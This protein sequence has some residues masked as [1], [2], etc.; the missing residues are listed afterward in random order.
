MDDDSLHRVEVHRRDGRRA[1][2]LLGLQARQSIRQAVD[3]VGERTAAVRMLPTYLIVGAQ[4]GGTSALYEYLVR[5]PLIGRSTNE[6]VHYFSVNFYRGVD[7]YKGHFPT[8]FHRRYTEL[9][10]GRKLITG[11]SSPYYMFHPHAP[12]RIADLLP[13]VRLIVALRNPVDRAYS[14]YIHSVRMGFEDLGTFE[15]ALEAEPSRLE[16]ETQRML[17]DP[18]YFGFSHWH[19]SYIARG[20]YLEQL[21]RLHELFQPD[22]ILVVSAEDMRTDTTAVHATVLKFLGL[23]V[24]TFSTYPRHNVGHYSPMASTTRARLVK[25]FTEPNNSLVEFLG[26]DFHWN[27]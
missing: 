22:Q 13:N 17:A 9:I 10:H 4:K 8:I 18:S 23:P 24:I 25:H 1:R 7:W 6:E 20:L 21:Q 5:H 15:S 3:S 14:Q 16:P 11:E 26:R 12:R 27:M 2:F 19:H